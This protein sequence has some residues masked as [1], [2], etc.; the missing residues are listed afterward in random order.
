MASTA[1]QPQ[2]VVVPGSSG[3]RVRDL[4][5][6]RTVL[7]IIPAAFIFIVFFVAPVAVMLAMAFNPSEVGLVGFSLNDLTLET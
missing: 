2:T 5:A 4:R 7:L 1:A 3:K 6:D